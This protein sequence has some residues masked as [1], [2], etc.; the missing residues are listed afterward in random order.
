MKYRYIN[1]PL[2]FFI[3]WVIMYLRKIYMDVADIESFVQHTAKKLE[4][5]YVNS[6]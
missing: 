4:R 2:T 6:F 1:K 3:Q 5:K